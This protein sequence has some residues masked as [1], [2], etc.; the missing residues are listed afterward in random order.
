MEPPPNQSSL[1][2]I[3]YHHST[4]AG[5]IP[6]ATGSQEADAKYCGTNPHSRKGQALPQ[7]SAHAP[8]RPAGNRTLICEW[9]LGCRCLHSP[10]QARTEILLETTDVWLLDRNR[11]ESPSESVAFCRRTGTFGFVIS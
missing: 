7:G 6:P 9:S 2:T 11:L 5:S 1:Q 4:R 10:S 3:R 8:S